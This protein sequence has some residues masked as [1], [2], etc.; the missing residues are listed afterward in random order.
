MKWL[1]I[2]LF[3]GIVSFIPGISG[4]T[5]LYMSGEY[6]NFAYY[7]KE[8][9]KHKG[10]LLM[11]VLGLLLGVFGFAKV[12]EMCFNNFPQMT[13]LFFSYLIILTLP[14]FIK[15]KHIKIKPLYVFLGFVFL[16]FI[17]YLV[18][19]QSLVINEYP[20]FNLMFF[21][22]FA[23]CGFLDGFITI[24]PGIS[25]SMV[26]MILGPYYLYKSFCANAFNKPILLLF[27][28]GYFI[29]DLLGI[30]LGANI[31]TKLFNKKKDITHSIILGMVISSIAIIMPISSVLSLPSL[32]LFVIAFIIMEWISLNS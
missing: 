31:T 5:I 18:P 14:S 7:L 28:T 29:G 11:L 2:G 27:L 30:I 3:I 24:I 1:I 16:L 17:S 25:G 20:K 15:D 26:M 10:I 19:E 9:K 32:I 23:L 6:E 8:Y 22:L 21:I 12:I 13:L 4:G